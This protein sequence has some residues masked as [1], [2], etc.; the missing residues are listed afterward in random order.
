MRSQLRSPTRCGGGSAP[1]PAPPGA[2]TRLHGPGSVL[3]RRRRSRSVGRAI[4]SER[5]PRRSGS[6][7]PAPP[8][9]HRRRPPARPRHPPPPAAA[10]RGGR[11]GTARVSLLQR[12]VGP[13]PTRSPSPRQGWAAAGG[14]VPQ[15]PAPGRGSRLGQRD[16]QGPGS[17]AS[18]P[19]T[20]CSERAAASQSHAPHELLEEAA[21]GP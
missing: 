1:T 17:P 7:H 2:P 15:V 16:P 4:Y 13:P 20:R 19:G 10:Q 9:H 5:R 8:R 6:R 3:F 14:W 21:D 18:G 11:R 12:L